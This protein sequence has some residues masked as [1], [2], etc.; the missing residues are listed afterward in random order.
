M[1]K[2]NL[3]GI[4]SGAVVYLSKHSVTVRCYLTMSEIELIAESMMKT[5]NRI[6]EIV[7]RDKMLIKLATDITEEEAEDYDYIV[8]SGLMDDI[9]CSIYNVDIIDEYIHQ[10][11]SVSI[12]MIAFLE[13]VSKSLDKYNKK[14]PTG[15]E[16]EKI[17]NEIKEI[18]IPGLGK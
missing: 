8:K 9:I 5:K 4:N 10:K 13:T 11:R 14:L 18:Q 12:A 3:E 2:L 17:L 16:L 6:E 7:L 15:K 1:K